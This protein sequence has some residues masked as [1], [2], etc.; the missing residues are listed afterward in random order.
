M[1]SATLTRINRHIDGL[2]ACGKLPLRVTRVGA[3]E[4]YGLRMMVTDSYGWELP[5]EGIGWGQK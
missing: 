1:S 5:W 4:G 2:I 3:D